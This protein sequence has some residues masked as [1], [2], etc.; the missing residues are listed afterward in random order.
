MPYTLLCTKFPSFMVWFM[1]VFICVR[2]YEYTTEV[3]GG[4]HMSH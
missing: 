3:R 2:V 4:D 1:S